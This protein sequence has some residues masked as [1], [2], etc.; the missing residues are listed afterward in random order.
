MWKI[1]SRHEL[2]CCLIFSKELVSPYTIFAP[3][4]QAFMKLSGHNLTLFRLNWYI[5]DIFFSSIYHR[6]GVQGAS[7]LSSIL[8][9]NCRSIA[10]FF[11]L[12]LSI[13]NKKIFADY[14]YFFVD[15]KKK[16]PQT[17]FKILTIHKPSLESWIFKKYWQ[18]KFVGGK[19]KTFPGIM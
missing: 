19:L 11:L 2:I 4:N 8:N 3:T 13:N 14:S 16:I 17:Y 9:F 5:Y 6:L 10:A 1:I 15:L 18:L 7:R 12:K